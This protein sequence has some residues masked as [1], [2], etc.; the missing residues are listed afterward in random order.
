MDAPG[1][2]PMAFVTH[3]GLFECTVM[4]F[5]LTNAP[6]TLQPLMD[7]VLAGLKWQCCLVYLDDIIVYSSTFEQ[8]L[9]DLYKVF[10]ALADANL[11]LKT[12][13]C[14]FCQQEIKF[15]GHFITP[16]GAKPDPCLI[17]TIEQF[18]QPTLSCSPLAWNND[19]TVA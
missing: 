15:L 8:H 5:G 12:S 18:P 7:I 6:A 2:A 10:L 3:K 11:T 13:K 1:K 9:E 19:C 14:N 17:A 4:H 16:N